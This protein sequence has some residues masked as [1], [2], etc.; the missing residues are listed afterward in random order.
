VLG[1]VAGVGVAQAKPTG[2][3]PDV[4]EAFGEPALRNSGF[5]LSIKTSS[6]E[7]TAAAG[8][9]IFGVADRAATPLTLVGDSERLLSEAC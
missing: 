7:C 6:L 9:T 5:V 1:I 2:E 4:V 8:L 3:R